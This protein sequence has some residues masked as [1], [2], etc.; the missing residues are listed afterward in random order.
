[1]KPSRSKLQIIVPVTRLHGKSYNLEKW[2]S[3]L[4]DS[5]VS[6]VLVH[7]RQDEL[8]SAVL[9]AIASQNQRNITLVE[10]IFNS[11]G[12]ARNAGRNLVESDWT[13]FVD[14]DDLPDVRAAIDGIADA[15][16]ETE[17]IVGDF[18]I[19]SQGKLTFNQTSTCMR[20]LVSVAYNPGLWRMIFRSDTLENTFFKTYRMAEDQLFLLEYGLYSRKLFFFNKTVYTYFK[21]VSGQL[22]S[23]RFAIQE[24]NLVISET[25]MIYSKSNKPEKK[26][27]AVML[28]RQIATFMRFSSARR[29]ASFF[30]RGL[31]NSRKLKI[32]EYVALIE[33]ALTIMR[34]RLE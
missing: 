7:D 11:P 17:V 9:S 16:P 13:W 4:P 27:I 21:E 28:M 25:W 33:A 34:M 12:V 8:T 2:L 10:G 24:I 29:N 6:V 31:G 22:T 20:P 32:A 30:L 3:N 26:L 14:A 15:K 23:N 19:E 5:Q 18:Q 1:M